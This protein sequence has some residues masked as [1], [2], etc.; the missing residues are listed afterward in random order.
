MANQSGLSLTQVPEAA[1]D[2]VTFSFV[3]NWVVN[4]NDFFAALG[5][6]ISPGTKSLGGCYV[7]ER[8]NT[9][10]WQC[11]GTTSTDPYYAVKRQTVGIIT[12]VTEEKYR[13]VGLPAPKLVV[14]ADPFRFLTDGRL[15]DAIALL[16]QQTRGR[17]VQLMRTLPGI[18]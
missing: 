2:L 5:S 10:T 4:V 12:A 13:V 1:I 15:V 7:V 17:N 8:L 6:F 14:R 9:S 11:T 18:N 3:L 16:R